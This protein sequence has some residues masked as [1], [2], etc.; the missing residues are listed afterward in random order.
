[1][2]A[3]PAVRRERLVVGRIDVKQPDNHEHPED[4]QFHQYHDVVRAG[5]LAHTDVKQA[6]DRHH[7]RERRKV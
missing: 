7:N 5:T 3:G 4:E 2:N 6:C 1:M